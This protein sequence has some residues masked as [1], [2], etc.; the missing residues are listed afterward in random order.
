MPQ[1]TFDIC[2]V[3]WTV[4]QIFFL[5]IKCSNWYTVLNYLLLSEKVDCHESL[6]VFTVRFHFIESLPCLL[7]SLYLFL[8]RREGWIL[9]GDEMRWES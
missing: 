8:S 9:R 3:K 6:T 4:K 2:E 7:A 5:P 1:S